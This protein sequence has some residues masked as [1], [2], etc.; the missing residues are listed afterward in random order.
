M[1]SLPITPPAKARVDLAPKSSS[2][3]S[4]GSGL[5]DFA[6][7]LNQTSARTAPAEGQNTRPASSEQQ[8]R[9]RDD[10]VRDGRRAADRDDHAST[11]A[12]S[13]PATDQP[14]AQDADGSPASDPKN[15]GQQAPDKD[16]GTPADASAAAQQP[17]ATTTDAQKAAAAAAAL[18]AAS[19]ATPSGAPAPATASTAA[20][21]GTTAT[22]ATALDLATADAAALATANAGQAAAGQAADGSATA[23]TDAAGK[24]QIPAEL[25]GGKA[26]N[27]LVTAKDTKNAQD[28]LPPLPTLPPSAGAA[29]AAPPT[30]AAGGDAGANAGQQGAQSQAQPQLAPSVAT[31]QPTATPLTAVPTAAGSP[32]LT[33][34]SLVQT[35]ERVH[36]LVRIATTRSGNARAT[37]QL[38]P[39][40]LGQIDV[41]LR[42]TKDGLVA[43]IAAHDQAGLDALQNAANELRRT[44]SDRG[45][46]LHS[47]DLQLGSGDTGFSNQGDA[48]QANSGRSGSAS[49]YGLED[50]DVVAEDELTLTTP[51]STPAG[52]LVDVQA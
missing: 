36:E 20:G 17:A 24:L 10:D 7:L 13:T 1:S 50:D 5:G 9:R 40:A 39:E 52:A 42:T 8:T 28:G 6:A 21:A 2:P 3:P 43:T 46:E 44:L 15:G 29:A 51:T 23:G 18:A 14:K 48:R 26:P 31:G 38:K 47:L 12:A 22:G 35:A 45:V 19:T 27:K 4:G 11:D 25:L 34:G 32:Q 30:G 41:Q 49:S 16:A 37:L 33:K